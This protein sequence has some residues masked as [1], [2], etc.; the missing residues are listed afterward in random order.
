MSR[1]LVSERTGTIS[2]AAGTGSVTVDFQPGRLA[3][4]YLAPTSESTRFDFKFTDYHNLDTF[5][6]EDIQGIYSETDVGEP[7]YDNFTLT[8]ENATADEDFTYLLAVTH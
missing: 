5:V 6:E 8:I 3:K 7:I 4:I 1:L 2:V